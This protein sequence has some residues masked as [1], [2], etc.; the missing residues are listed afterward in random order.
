MFFFR[1]CKISG[2]ALAALVAATYLHGMEAIRYDAHGRRDPLVPLVG[3][4]KSVTTKLKD[5]TSIYEIN[6]EGIAMGADGKRL[7]ILNG[8]IIRESEKT[9]ELVIK[10]IGPN[11]IILHLDGNEHTVKLS[12]EGGVKSE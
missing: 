3:Q 10:K 5:V 2:L 11:S 1:A 6:L 9:G 8:E 4:E 12:E 7:A